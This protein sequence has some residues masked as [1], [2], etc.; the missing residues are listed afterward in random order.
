MERKSFDSF[1]RDVEFPAYDPEDIMHVLEYYALKEAEPEFYSFDDIDKRRLDVS[2]IAQKIYDDDMGPRAQ[3]AY[4]NSVWDQEDDNI[5]RLFF[6]RKLYFL[7]HV[8]IELGK[9]MHPEEYCTGNNVEYGKRAIEDMSLS[10]MA[11]Y[12]PKLE[13]ELR[14]AVFEK[15]IDNNGRYCCAR[16]GKTGKTRRGFQVDHIIP[17]NKGGKTEIDNLQI[18]C[19]K[20]NGYKGDR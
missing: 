1:F 6:G 7:K 13:R 12:A 17:L 2:L 15:S 18:L 10:E 5:L 8:E 16:C 4:L 11:Q 20:C 9:L 3:S 19:N 14:N